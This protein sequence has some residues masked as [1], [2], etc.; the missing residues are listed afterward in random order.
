MEAIALECA[1]CKAR[2]KIKASSVRTPVEVKCPKCGKMI[3][4]AK[5]GAGGA[6]AST[7]PSVPTPAPSPA[8][9]APGPVPP[10][11]PAPRPE[12]SGIRKA[13]APIVLNTAAELSTLTV[14]VS[15]SACQWHTKVAAPLIGKKIRCK[16]CGGIIP[17]VAPNSES[18]PPTSA[19]PPSFQRVPLTAPAA[20][21]VPTAPVAQAIEPPPPPE[22]DPVQ[23]TDPS[24]D[25]APV[26]DA[27]PAPEVPVEPPPSPVRTKTDS[28]QVTL[29]SIALQGE[30][31]ELKAQLQIARQH[32]R[33]AAD[34][35]SAAE[36][37]AS[38]A[39]RQAAEAIRRTRDAEKMLHD[40]AGQKAVESMT[41]SRK[42]SELEGK[43]RDI[44]EILMEIAQNY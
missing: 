40:M 25:A 2:L 7:A 20:P 41:V 33:E 24:Q 32:A 21:P 18:V 22:A 39:E 12:E 28:G 34:R 26:Q 17:V 15:C 13:A 4:V 38:D 35:A 30:I 8:P 10:P 27:A 43:L 16:Q 37:H 3:P 6:P 23:N 5:D 44:Q 31:A 36:Q 11:L 9:T 19:H 42:R 29:A 14:P 1:N